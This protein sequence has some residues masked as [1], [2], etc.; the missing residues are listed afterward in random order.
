MSVLPTCD[1]CGRTFRHGYQALPIDVGPTGVAHVNPTIEIRNLC[2]PCAAAPSA[3]PTPATSPRRERRYNPAS[4][5]R[6]NQRAKRGTPSG[7]T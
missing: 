3:G 4:A 6:A 5:W 7:G 1:T 2:A